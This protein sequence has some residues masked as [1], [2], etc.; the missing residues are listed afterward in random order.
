MND[1]FLFLDMTIEA[2]P[3]ADG[4]N[5]ASGHTLAYVPEIVTS[6]TPFFGSCLLLDLP[7][8][9]EQGSSPVTAQILQQELETRLTGANEQSQVD[10]SVPGD[11]KRVLLKTKNGSG[12]IDVDW[13]GYLKVLKDKQI[14]LVGTDAGFDHKLANT[15]IASL[16][17]LDLS[18]VSGS[19]LGILSGGPAKIEGQRM[20]PCRAVLIFTEGG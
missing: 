18:G 17:N 14:L 12:S 2:S 13:E 4:T 7:S 6:L 11:V 10:R 1:E 9:Q 19:Q 8:L 15:E 3:D 20:V 16:V 5:A